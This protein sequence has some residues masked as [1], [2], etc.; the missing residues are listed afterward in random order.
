MSSTPRPSP[1]WHWWRP[2]WLRRHSPRSGG[3]G[4]LK[5]ERPHGRPGDGWFPGLGWPRLFASE[6]RMNLSIIDLDDDAGRRR[7][8]QVLGRGADRVAAGASRLIRRARRTSGAV[9]HDAEGALDGFVAAD[10]NSVAGVDRRWGPRDGGDVP[11]RAVL[12]RG[13]V[14]RVGR[15]AAF[16]FFADDVER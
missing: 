13:A 12:E 10:A 6:C 3:V 7:R 5:P 15:V 2:S 4:Y 9:D 16:G 1:G 8:E 14:R 11:Q